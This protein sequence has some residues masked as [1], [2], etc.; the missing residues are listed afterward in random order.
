MDHVLPIVSQAQLDKCFQEPIPDRLVRP[1]VGNE[2]KRNSL[3]GSQGERAFFLTR[4]L[5]I[6]KVSMMPRKVP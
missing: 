5:L 2:H 4:T 1:I 6:E 3:R